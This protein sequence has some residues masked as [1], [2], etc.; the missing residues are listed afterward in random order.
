M[1]CA[2]I[3]YPSGADRE[4]EREGGGIVELSP[5]KLQLLRQYKCKLRVREIFTFNTFIVYIKDS[6]VV[7]QTSLLFCVPRVLKLRFNR[8]NGHQ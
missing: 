6:A 2:V 3:F 5:A 8:R 1:G 4:R 7:I